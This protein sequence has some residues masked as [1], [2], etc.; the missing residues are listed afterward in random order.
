MIEGLRALPGWQ[1]ALSDG[2]VPAYQ[3]DCTTC[4]KNL[5]TTTRTALRCGFLPL[6]EVIAHGGKTRA[7]SPNYMR[8]V[9]GLQVC[10]GY[11]TSLAEVVEVRDCFPQWKTGN[12]A[13]FTVERPSPEL[14]D[15]CAALE[16]AI[17]AKANQDARDREEALH[18]AR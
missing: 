7:W 12:L 8:D 9:G 2:V 18:G 1:A 4:M 15:G 6:V 17:N 13:Y 14:V 5:D 10:A 16:G 3:S 11:T